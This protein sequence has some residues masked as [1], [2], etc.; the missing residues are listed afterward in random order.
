[1]TW[2]CSFWPGFLRGPDTRNDPDREGVCPT[3]AGTLTIQCERPL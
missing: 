1:M 2:L 3:L